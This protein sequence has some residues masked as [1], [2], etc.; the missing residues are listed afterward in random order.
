MSLYDCVILQS[1]FNLIPLIQKEGSICSFFPILININIPEKLYMQ[2]AG[3]A[4][5]EVERSNNGK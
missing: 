4:L 2:P 3:F 5:T 1:A